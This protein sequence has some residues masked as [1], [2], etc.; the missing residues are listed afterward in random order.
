[1]TGIATKGGDT[2][3]VKAKATVASKK[4]KENKGEQ[5]RALKK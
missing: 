4:E 5:E 1:M 3:G 2:G